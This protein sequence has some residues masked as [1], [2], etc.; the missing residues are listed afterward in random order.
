MQSLPH[1]VLDG[2][3]LAAAAIGAEEVIV[4]ACESARAG[5]QAACQRLVESGLR[6]FVFGLGDLVLLAFHFNLE[7]FLLDSVHQSRDGLC[8]TCAR[9]FQ[10][11]GSGRLIVTFFLHRS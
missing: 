3:Q 8:T 5:A 9:H 7:Q 10:S 6:L 4:C 2:G 11:T 1:L